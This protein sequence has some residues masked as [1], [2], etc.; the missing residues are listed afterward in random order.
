MS[1]LKLGPREARGP[2]F[3]GITRSAKRIASSTSFVIRM[4][5]FFS[6][7]ERDAAV[8][9]ELA[10]LTILRTREEHVNGAVGEPSVFGFT[11]VG[12]PGLLRPFVEQVAREIGRLGYLATVVGAEAAAA[13]I[14]WYSEVERTHDFVLYV[15]ETTDSGWRQW[16]SRQ[17]DRLFRLAVAGVSPDKSKRIDL[18]IDK[19]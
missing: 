12:Q 8:M 1:T 13:P 4:M 15:A 11:P 19:V 18:P 9:T 10:R 6:A 16:V 2:G 14:E 7:C 3:S 17:A 5:V